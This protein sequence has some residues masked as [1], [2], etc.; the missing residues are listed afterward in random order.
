MEICELNSKWSQS[1]HG[2]SSVTYPADRGCTRISHERRRRLL[3]EMWQT[4]NDRVMCWLKGET[5]VRTVV[6]G[7]EI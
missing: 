3:W 5:E 6:G 2:S 7:N 1:T 4:G